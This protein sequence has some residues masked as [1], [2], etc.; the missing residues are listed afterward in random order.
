MRG[1]PL[2]HEPGLGESEG[3]QLWPA[4]WVTNGK[5]SCVSGS[6]FDHI[7]CFQSVTKDPK[8]TLPSPC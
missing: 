3:A 4:I 1:V 8:Y 7:R 2:V 5:L 6:Q